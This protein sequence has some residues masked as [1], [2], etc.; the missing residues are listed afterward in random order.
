MKIFKK[1][2]LPILV[3]GI[4]INLSET[5]RWELII[6][7]F[8]VES[9]EEI[10]LVFPTALW[11][12]IMWLVWGFMMATVV[13][14]LSKKF[15]IIQTTLLSWSVVFV[16]LWLVLFNIEILPPGILLYNVPLSLLE[17]FVAAFICKR[18]S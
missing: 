4:W 13:F 2:L 14:I 17:V 5:I 6:K 12:N 9:Y 7:S 8:W 15:N 3:T 10:G 11:N 1:I 16:L 18:L